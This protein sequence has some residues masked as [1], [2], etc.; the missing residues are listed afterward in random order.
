MTHIAIAEYPGAQQAAVLGLRDLFQVAAEFTEAQLTVSVTSHFDDTDRL[1]DVVILPPSMGGWPEASDATQVQAWI[2]AQHKGRALVCSVCAGAFLLAATG[3]LDGRPVTTHWE[4]AGDFSTRFPSVR[5]ETEKL[6]IDD[7]DLITV[8]GM[9]AWTDLGLLLIARY[10]GPA[11]MQK[12]AKTFLIDPGAREQSY[13][14]LFTPDM[15]HGDASVIHAQHF[16]G[17]GYQGRISVPQMA[18]AAGLEERTFLRRFQAATGLRPTEYLQQL[19]ISQARE[20]LETTRKTIGV[21]A[22]QVGYSDVSSFSRLFQKTTGLA[23]GEYRKRFA[24]VH[25]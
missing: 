13:Y 22:V 17:A 10:L 16:L 15:S 2:E 6:I 12:T 19:R 8:G 14:N 11:V 20:L 24:P 7:G 3:L 1:Y 18:E 5:L 9:M 25:R 4:L 21:I 23:P